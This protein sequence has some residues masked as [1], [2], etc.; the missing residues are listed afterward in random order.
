MFRIK[1]H[2]KIVFALVFCL[3]AVAVGAVSEYAYGASTF[4]V[5][6]NTSKTKDAKSSKYYQGSPANDRGLEN[7]AYWSQGGSKYYK[8]ANWGCHIVAYSKLLSEVGCDLPAGFDPD[9]LLKWGQST[10]FN[11]RDVFVYSGL[12]ESNVAGVAQMPCV[13]AASRGFRLELLGSSDNPGVRLPGN[14]NASGYAEK[15]ANRVKQADKIMKYLNQG[16]YVILGCS[17]H[18]TYVLREESLAAGTP[19]ISDSRSV[20][21]ASSLVENFI[22]YKGWSDPPNYT[23]MYVYRASTPKAPTPTPLPLSYGTVT[24]GL[25]STGEYGDSI[26]MNVG[27]SALMGFKGA[28][29]YSRD[30][31][32]QTTEWVS[33][34][35]K[36]ATVETNGR[37]TALKFGNTKIRF[38]VTV[39][40]T[41]TIYSGEVAVS[42]RYPATPTPTPI[43]AVKL[44]ISLN[45]L[46]KELDMVEGDSFD[47]DSLNIG[48][49][50][51]EDTEVTWSSASETVVS[52]MDGHII[53]ALRAGTCPIR[54]IAIDNESGERYEGKFTVNVTKLTLEVMLSRMD[55]LYDMVTFMMANAIYDD[56]VT[57]DYV[58]DTKVQLLSRGPEDIKEMEKMSKVIVAVPTLWNITDFEELMN[59][60]FVQEQLSSG[61]SFIRNGYV[62]VKK[63]NDYYF[64]FAD[65][66]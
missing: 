4:S 45:T 16:Y 55:N 7:W 57:A 61:V 64:I 11:G 2:K 50:I 49:Q 24:L 41:N 33:E 39:K 54:C 28:V 65:L 38:T 5:D 36:V 27:D 21:Y 17:A 13:Y 52:V 9:Y 63:N 1:D 19:V 58:Y 51:A 60:D 22:D 10:K 20:S 35:P 53:K 15:R 42:I 14:A 56:N 25:Q 3:L 59:T 34:N 43:P 12:G 29:G 32:G 8:M 23:V 46:T 47:L 6:R 37:I 62:S 31:D 48:S 30:T 44:D 40:A 18:F 26:T 66:S